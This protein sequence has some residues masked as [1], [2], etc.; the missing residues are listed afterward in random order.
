AGAATAEENENAPGFRFLELITGLFVGL[1]IISNLASTRIIAFGPLVFD[2]GTLVFPLTYVIGDLLTEVY[3][4]ARARRIIWT[5]FFS[6]FAAFFCLYV[7]GLFPGA[8]DPETDKAWHSVMGI[9]PRIAI[10][11]LAAFLAG[12]FANSVTLAKL[13]FRS[14]ERGPAGRFVLS[15]LV[16]QGFDT[17][18]FVFVAFA[19]VLEGSVL[20]AVL[21]SNYAYKVA[22]EIIILPLSV[23]LSKKLK[24]AER[25]EDRPGSFAGERAPGLNPFVWK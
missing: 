19:G 13:K 11:S 3:G 7:A 1:L 12:E 24:K 21:C 8:S 6:L 15:T 20:L 16:G 23:F 22:M 5:A 18:I 25:T 17:T 14:P 9:A 2:A 4:F 10:A